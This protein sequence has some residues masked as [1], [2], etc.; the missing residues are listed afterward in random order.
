[1]RVDIVE[2]GLCRIPNG[3]GLQDGVIVKR[4][5]GTIEDM[6]A[7]HYTQRK[8]QPPLAELPVCQDERV[9]DRS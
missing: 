6:P 3:W 7:Y 4:V 5:D 9:A 1:M 2:N 8:L